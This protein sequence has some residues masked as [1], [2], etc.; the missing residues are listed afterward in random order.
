MP[1]ARAGDDHVPG[2]AFLHPGDIYEFIGLAGQNVVA[3]ARWLRIVRLKSMGEL[4]VQFLK[5]DDNGQPDLDTPTQERIIAIENAMTMI[6]NGFWQLR[7][8]GA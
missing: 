7:I 8:Q 2:D 4:V 5:Q 1:P 6:T 3:V